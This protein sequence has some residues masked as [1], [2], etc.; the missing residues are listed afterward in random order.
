MF[1]I[2][3]VS[4]D[5]NSFCAVAFVLRTDQGNLQAIVPFEHMPFLLLLLRGPSEAAISC[6]T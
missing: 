4:Q 1:Q 6:A 5:L 3:E 2:S